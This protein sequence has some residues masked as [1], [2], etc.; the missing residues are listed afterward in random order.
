VRLF[1]L[2]ATG[3][4]ATAIY[5]LYVGHKPTTTIPGLIISLISIAFMWALVLGKRKVGGALG[6]NAILADANCSV[7]CIY[8]SAV[9]LAA[10]LIYQFTGF[11]FCGQP[12]RAWLD[13]LFNQ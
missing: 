6:S 7:V 1:Y 11:G 13:L 5:N 3:L 8:M 9:L 2:L 10:S 4:A 12:R